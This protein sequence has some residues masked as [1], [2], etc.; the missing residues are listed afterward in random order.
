MKYPHSG[1]TRPPDAKLDAGS[2][3]GMPPLSREQVG[4]LL[5]MNRSKFA[6]MVARR[7][8]GKL[9]ANRPE[10]EDVLSS[11]IRRVDELCACGELRASSPGEVW[12]LAIAIA[13][14]VIAQRLRA[15]S[16]AAR[17]SEAIGRERPEGVPM[18]EAEAPTVTLARSMV[19]SMVGPQDVELLQLKLR[20]CGYHEIAGATQSTTAAVRQ[21]WV[22]IRRDL[23]KRF[24]GFGPK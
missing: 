6:A 13:N 1:V 11:S 4:S 23:Q 21:R 16:V 10:L 22:R 15:N 3:L 14:N 20:G 18:S 17:H 12:A 9:A 5:V 19:Q 24:S 8:R 7:L 2:V